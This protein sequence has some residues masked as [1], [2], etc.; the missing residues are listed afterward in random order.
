[1][2]E[3]DTLP[4]LTD[5][6]EGAKA[7][8]F[9]VTGR[10]EL[11]LSQGDLGSGEVDRRHRPGARYGESKAV[12][13]GCTDTQDVVVWPHPKS[14]LE[15]ARIFP[16]LRIG[17]SLTQRLTR[18]FRA[19]HSAFSNTSMVPATASSRIRSPVAK[20]SITPLTATTEGMPISRATTAE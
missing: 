16:R 2:V 12:V 14:R 18:G 3:E 10:R 17:D 1:M 8:K 15:H 11:E 9:K 19:A 7:V 4:H 13:T 6:Q 20:A 5:A